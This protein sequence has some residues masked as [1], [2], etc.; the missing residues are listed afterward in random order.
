MPNFSSTAIRLLSGGRILS[1]SIPMSELR[2]ARNVRAKG[3]PRCHSVQPGLF[4]RDLLPGWFREVPAR[5]GTDG[6]CPRPLPGLLVS[7][8]GQSPEM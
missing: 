4:R 2:A 8:P 3:L 7:V 6:C 5:K 1:G